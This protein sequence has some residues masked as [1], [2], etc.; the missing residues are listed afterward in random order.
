MA[1]SSMQTTWSRIFPTS[2]FCRDR[3]DLNPG[4]AVVETPYVR[5]LVYR[6]EVDNDYHEHVFTTRSSSIVH[7]VQA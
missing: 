2:A 6:L 7:P 4:I 5:D 3:H 1:A